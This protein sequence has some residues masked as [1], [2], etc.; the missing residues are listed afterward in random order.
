MVSARAA[1][2][3]SGVVAGFLLGCAPDPGPRQ[4]VLS[5]M[6]CPDGRR[7]MGRPCV[8]EAPDG[9][10]GRAIS[11]AKRADPPGGTILSSRL[12]GGS[13]VNGSGV[14]VDA[15]G[16]TYVTGS[17]TQAAR[18]GDLPALVSEGGSDAFVVKLDASGEPVWA[19]RFG[20]TGPDAAQSVVVDTDGSL[21]VSG[22]FESPQIDL[23]TGPLSCAGIEDLFLAKMGPDG[24]TL[25]AKRYGDTQSQIDM[26]LRRHPAGG[27]IA[28]GF[29]NGTV[30]FGT[31]PVSRPW[32]KA[33][34]AASIDS[35]GR[36]RWAAAFGRRLD[37][38][39]TSS[40]VDSQGRVFVSAG[41]DTTSD[42]A[43]AAP[44]VAGHDLGPVL[45][46]FGADGKRTAGRRFGAGA[47]NLTTALA[48]DGKDG[49]RLAVASRGA[50]RFGEAVE[51]PL[52]SGD[53]R[54]VVTSF[55]PAGAVVWS[56]GVLDG[57]SLSVSAAL[58]DAAGSTYVV[59]Q[60]TEQLGGSSRSNGFVVKVTAS[61]DVA[62]TRLVA[63]GSRAWLS[64]LAFDAQ[65][66]LVIVGSVAGLDSQNQLYVARLEP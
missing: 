10:W 46:G 34:F 19:R 23:G 27:V 33:F 6:T 39:T 3:G 8:D 64:D 1:S 51:R 21:Y 65:G 55:D 49:L 28:T 62:W 58:A 61:G 16:A 26:V 47:D 45:L 40:V 9:T 66:R 54:L 31:G 44:G 53:T 38:A 15:S 30:D 13:R 48:I 35:D 41:S 36:G 17:F 56:K 37:Y 20:G 59:G 25:W 2:V 14:A 42:I 52:A 50:T 57:G 11:V 7:W 32:G 18:F 5:E 4:P 60:L 24:E 43:E 12:Y 29:H 22:N 63:D